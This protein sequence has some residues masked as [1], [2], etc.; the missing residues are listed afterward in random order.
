MSGV[1]VVLVAIEQVRAND[2]RCVCSLEN[3][4]LGGIER[5]VDRCVHRRDSNDVGRQGLR[6]K[7]QKNDIST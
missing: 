7:G 1:A 6:G 2:D 4:G 5:A 3:E